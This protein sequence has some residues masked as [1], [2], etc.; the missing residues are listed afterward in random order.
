MY[1]YNEINNMS[2]DPNIYEN[3]I[4][5]EIILLFEKHGT[6]DYIGENISQFEHMAQA[7]DLAERAGEDLEIILA[8]FLHDIGHLLEIDHPEKHM[9]TLGVAN[10]EIIA[11]QYLLSKGFGQKIATLVKNHVDAKR[12]LV[13]INPEY[14]DKL[15]PAS[16]ATLLN[17]QNGHMTEAELEKF[18]T[19]IYFKESIRIRCY[20]DNAKIIGYKTKDLNY[21]K[22]LINQFF[23]K[24]KQ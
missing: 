7:A 2:E 17:H 8:A 18:R 10:H 13:T 6:S 24:L 20:D 4:A 12:Y 1:K 9:S 22:D 23:A 16:R 5:E 15:S 14:Y 21:Y 3:N 11:Y 19:D